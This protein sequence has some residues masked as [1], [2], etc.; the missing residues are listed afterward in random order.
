MGELAEGDPGDYHRVF[1]RAHRSLWKHRGPT[2]EKNLA[3]AC[4][5]CNLL[6]G[7][8]I[9]SVDMQTGQLCRT[10]RCEILGGGTFCP[11]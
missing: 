1:I 5:L 2:L 3:W 10:K 8:D 11:D 6:K 9:A 4:Y 7:T